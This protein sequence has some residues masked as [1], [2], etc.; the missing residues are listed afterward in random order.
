MAI[1]E[2]ARLLLRQRLVEVLGPDPAD[3]LMASL[4]VVE[5]TELATKRDLVALR[6]ELGQRIDEQGRALRAEIA[7]LGTELRGEIAE[8]RGEIAGV[9]GEIATLGADLRTEMTVSRGEVLTTILNQ[10]SA[11]LRVMVVAMLVTV[12]TTVGIVLAAVGFSS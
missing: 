2:R 10:Q 4:P 5:W 1:D 11:N 12:L 3:T 7:I 6:D 8:V 9:R